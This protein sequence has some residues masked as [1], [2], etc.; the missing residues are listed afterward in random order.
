V[1][2]LLVFVD[3]AGV[4]AGFE[5]AGIEAAAGAG[6]VEGFGLDAGA[7]DDEVIGLAEDAD[8]GFGDEEGVG[9]ELLEAAP[10]HVFTPLCPLHAPDLVAP[11]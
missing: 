1:V 5:G 4:D 11:L 8:E 9:F 3:A 10:H 2:A 7:E 6:G